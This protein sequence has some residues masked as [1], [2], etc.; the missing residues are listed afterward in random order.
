MRLSKSLTDHF[1]ES[2]T[3]WQLPFTTAHN[4]VMILS[5]WFYF[6]SSNMSLEQVTTREHCCLER[7][8]YQGIKEMTQKCLYV[9]V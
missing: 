1:Y 9:I 4:S 8:S 3:G 6:M 2:L 7:G 5:C